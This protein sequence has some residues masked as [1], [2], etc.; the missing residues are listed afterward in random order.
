M[1]RVEGK[2]WRDRFTLLVLHQIISLEMVTSD[3]WKC[4]WKGS[5]GVARLGKIVRLLSRG[6]YLRTGFG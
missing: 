4:D 6:T 1:I 2:E 3:V 5:N